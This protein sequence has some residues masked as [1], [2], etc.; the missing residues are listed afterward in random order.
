[1]HKK[2]PGNCV[3]SPVD[4]TGRL[5]R[6]EAVTT[7]TSRVAR[8]YEAHGTNYYGTLLKPAKANFHT[9]AGVKTDELDCSGT[10]VFNNVNRLAKT[11][12]NGVDM[13]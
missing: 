4:D 7:E 3:W 12:L 8:L 11:P 6:M 5:C 2:I 10:L 1:M 9:F 13:I